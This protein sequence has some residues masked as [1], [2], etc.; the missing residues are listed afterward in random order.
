MGQFTLYKEVGF[1]SPRALSTRMD[2]G[3]PW[4]RGRR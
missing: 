3:L 4:C 1:T 2:R